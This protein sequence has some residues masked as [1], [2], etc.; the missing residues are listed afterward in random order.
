MQICPTL[1]GRCVII[2]DVDH[3]VIIRRSLYSVLS[4][5]LYSYVGGKFKHFFQQMREVMRGW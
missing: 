3:D 5:I 1:Q 4:N 2:S